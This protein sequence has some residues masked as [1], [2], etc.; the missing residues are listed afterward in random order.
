MN[1]EIPLSPLHVKT[2]AT[3]HILQNLARLT[4]SFHHCHP[5]FAT[6][7][8]IHPLYTERPWTSEGDTYSYEHRGYIKPE[9]LEHW[10]LQ[11]FGPNKAKYVVSL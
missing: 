9:K 11:A 7:A 5:S 6:P 8:A 10:L 1:E 2:T 4:L 3:G